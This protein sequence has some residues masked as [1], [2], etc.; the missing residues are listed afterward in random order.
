MKRMTVTINVLR[1]NL[2]KLNKTEPL[3]QKQR[4]QNPRIS[5]IG[6]N[7][8]TNCEAY[9]RCTHTTRVNDTKQQFEVLEQRD[10]M[11]FC[12]KSKP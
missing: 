8:G 9:I 1:Q 4:K 12:V 10:T 6:S 2:T 11:W 7:P 3:P 5:L